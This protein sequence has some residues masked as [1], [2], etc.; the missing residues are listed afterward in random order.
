MSTAGIKRYRSEGNEEVTTKRGK[1]A[2]QEHFPSFGWND[3]PKDLLH[4]ILGF[5]FSRNSHVDEASII[6]VM[7][8]SKHWNEVATSPALWQIPQRGSLHPVRNAFGINASSEFYC[9][10]PTD[11]NSFRPSSF[12]GFVKLESSI[13]ALAKNDMS[14]FRALERST[15]QTFLLC[16]SPRNLRSKEILN[17]IFEK[18]FVCDKRGDDPQVDTDSSC[19]LYVMG[20]NCQRIILVYHD[21]PLVRGWS[22]MPWLDGQPVR[23]SLPAPHPCCQNNFPLHLLAMRNMPT[24]RISTGDWAIIVDWIFEVATCFNLGLRVVFSGME[25]FRRFVDGY[26]EETVR[27]TSCVLSCD[28]TVFT[29]PNKVMALSCTSALAAR[30][31]SEDEISMPR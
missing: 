30:T 20:S 4:H 31:S 8:V 3:L 29:Q 28:V 7:L 11:E 9:S 15:R 6:S 5:F 12:L 18:T 10:A 26:W 14:V 24:D 2:I 25:L 1:K 22:E 17:H 19:P 16:V 23:Q 21:R 27:A 13:C